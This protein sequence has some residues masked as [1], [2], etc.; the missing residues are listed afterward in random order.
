MCTPANRMYYY[1]ASALNLFEKLR[2]YY[3]TRGFIRYEYDPNSEDLVDYGKDIDDPIY[4]SH[5]VLQCAKQII[6]FIDYGLPL[7]G[8]NLR[9][10]H[11]DTTKS[12]RRAI[13]ATRWDGDPA[14]LDFTALEVRSILQKVVEKFSL[15]TIPP[16]ILTYD[17][18]ELLF[19]F[20]NQVERYEMEED[21]K[22]EQTIREVDGAIFESAIKLG[23]TARL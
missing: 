1:W 11:I 10:P 21:P 13:A 9:D 7:Y 23:M 2:K 15:E 18:K 5:H 19:R 16:S 14:S 22:A 3:Y 17:E 20:L 6:D 4:V 8:I 12:L